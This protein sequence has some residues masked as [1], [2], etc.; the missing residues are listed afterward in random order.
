MSDLSGAEASGYL[1]GFV[2]E[3]LRSH[4]LHI[5]SI[6]DNTSPCCAKEST[7]SYVQVVWSEDHGQPFRANEARLWV[8]TSGGM[9]GRRVTDWRRGV[10][11]ETE[12]VRDLDILSLEARLFRGG[13]EFRVN[14]LLASSSGSATAGLR[15]ARLHWDSYCVQRLAMLSRHDP[16]GTVFARTIPV[17]LLWRKYSI[18]EML[19]T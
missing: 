15:N 11:D 10:S 8:R 13:T 7:A 12:F 16:G 18:P 19:K 6:G 3:L 2:S 9:P 5:W 14:E 17:G 1:E 4:Y